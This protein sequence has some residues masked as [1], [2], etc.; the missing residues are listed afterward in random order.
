MGGTRPEAEAQTS[1]SCSTCTSVADCELTVVFHV[2][3]LLF[4]NLKL[5]LFLKKHTPA[6]N[7]VSAPLI[8]PPSVSDSI[9]SDPLG[10]EIDGSTNTVIVVA[11]PIC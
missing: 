10:K 1:D 11:N 4:V 9:Y 6:N 5:N 8:Y 3:N 7:S 2:L